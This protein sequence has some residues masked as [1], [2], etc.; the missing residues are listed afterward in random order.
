MTETGQMNA[1]GTGP[2]GVKRYTNLHSWRRDAVQLIT[3]QPGERA[4][5][6]AE[7]DQ[8]ESSE[9][10]EAV[11]SEEESQIIVDLDEESVPL[12]AGEE[13]SAEETDGTLTTYI[14]VGVIS[15]IVLILAIVVAL[16]IKK[17]S[18]K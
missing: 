11:E 17:R 10:S 16:V 7:A 18:K 13:D 15:A 8:Q 1:T 6:R 5:G 3:V 9:E 14:A 12:A 2:T 4:G